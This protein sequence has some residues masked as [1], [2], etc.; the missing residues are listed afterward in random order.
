MMVWGGAP[1][2]VLYCKPLEIRGCSLNEFSSPNHQITAVE[3]NCTQSG[4]PFQCVQY[5]ILWCTAPVTV[6]TVPRTYYCWYM[7]PDVCIGVIG[8]AGVNLCI[9]LLAMDTGLYSYWSIYSTSTHCTS[10]FKP[11]CVKMRS[12]GLFIV[13]D[14]SYSHTVCTVRMHYI[15]PICWCVAI[16]SLISEWCHLWKQ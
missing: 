3:H 7:R 12:T 8:V 13:H 14:T 6:C 11:M 2:Y 10:L 16:L 4:Y 5:T 1:P 9:Q 15:G